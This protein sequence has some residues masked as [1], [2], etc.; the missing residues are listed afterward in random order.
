MAHRCRERLSELREVFDGHGRDASRNKSDGP[1]PSDLADAAGAALGVS[2]E[3]DM[4]EQAERWDAK[5][6]HDGAN[7]V[8]AD[9][10]HGRR[11]IRYRVGE[12]PKAGEMLGHADRARLERVWPPGP[13]TDPAQWPADEAEPGICGAPNGVARWMDRLHMLG[14]GVVPLVAAYAFRALV[15]RALGEE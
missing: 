5:S 2:A 6:G 15:R 10:E 8:D 12:A 9:N 1:G 11:P 3:R 4:P 7:M 14:N 13:V